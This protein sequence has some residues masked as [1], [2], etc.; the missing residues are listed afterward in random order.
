MTARQQADGLAGRTARGVAWAFAGAAASRLAGLAATMVL[1]RLLAPEAFG[2]LAFALVLVAYGETV[3]DLGAGAALIFW[4][5]RREDAAQFTFWMNLAMGVLWFTALVAAAPLLAAFLG[6]PDGAPVVRAMAFSFP[7]KFLGSTHEAL[8]RKDLRFRTLVLPDVGLSVAKA[9][10]AVPLAFAGAGVWSLVVGHLVGLG[11]WTAL[12]WVRVP[13]RPSLRWPQGIAARMLRYGRDMVAVNV[14]AALVHHVDFIIVG[15][16]LGVAVL[17]YYQIAFRLPEMTVALLVRTVSRVLFPAF[18]TAHATSRDL[19][20]PYLAALRYV[21]LATLPASA[22]MFF[23]AGPLVAVLFGPGWE[24]SVPVLRAVAVYVALRS[25][26]THAGDVL[27]ATGRPGLLA[28]LGVG[29]AAILVPALV[30]AA[31]HGAPAVAW[32]LASVTALT[33]LLNLG[34]ACIAAQVRPGDLVRAARPSLLATALL[35]AVLA[36]WTNWA[37]GGVGPLG[38]ATAV[39]VGAAA[40]LAAVRVVAPGVLGAILRS[41][42]GGMPAGL[43]ADLP[44]GESEA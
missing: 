6:R 2:L 21:T 35:C 10:V 34:I 27:K 18:A 33:A 24:P 43:A 11:C 1:A 38:L 8:A 20:E 36:A 37:G 5:D 30:L 28:A 29:K 32:T 41:L 7:L 42:R 9:A 22:G 39:A 15:R 14:V 16:V 44:G 3:G 26:G 40:Y 23:L 25:V 12:L 4:P 13:W 19:R 17:G 31:P